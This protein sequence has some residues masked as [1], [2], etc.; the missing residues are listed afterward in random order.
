MTENILFNQGYNCCQ[1]VLAEYASRLDLPAPEAFRIGAAFGAG[2]G[3]R[4]HVCGAV[5]G[6]LMVIGLRFGRF[7]PEDLATRDL[8]HAQAQRFLNRFEE[9]HGSL[10][11][12]ELLGRD[13]SHPGQ[14]ELARQEQLFD[15]SCPGYVNG[16]IEILA[17]HFSSM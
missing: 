4:G 16:A 7:D 3:R 2:M 10:Y 9:E 15:R 14:Y 8:V 11:C 6:A 13:F 12:R 17:E 5:S 1:A